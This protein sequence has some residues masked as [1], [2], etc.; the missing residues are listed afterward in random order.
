ML[1]SRDCLHKNQGEEN[2]KKPVAKWSIHSESIKSRIM[3]LAFWFL[4]IRI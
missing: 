4:Y 1:S 3:F 2:N